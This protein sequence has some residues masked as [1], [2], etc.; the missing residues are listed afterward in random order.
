MRERKY[1]KFRVDMYEDTKLKI[2]DRKPERDLIN[3]IWTRVVI[4]AGKVN[5]EGDLFMS[6][7]IPYTIETLAI[8]FNRD[9]DHVELALNVL[10]ELEMIE[11]TEHKVYRVKNFAKH[12][13]IKVKEKVE[14]NKISN[15]AEI[16]KEEVRNE[17]IKNEEIKSEEDLKNESQIAI[18]EDIS[19]GSKVGE[20]DA[21][22]IKIDE[23][24]NLEITHKDISGNKEGMTKEKDSDNL[25]NNKSIPIEV[26]RG[27][28]KGR[29]K[30]NASIIEVIDGDIDSINDNVSGFF[31][32]ERPLGKDERIIK[33]WTFD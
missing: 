5:R 7:N 10:M 17:E 11:V 9:I 16:E 19:A 30:E 1:V 15:S 27:K 18:S 14:S 12:Q 2:I 6:K 3:Y 22:S 29:K 4:L 24:A 13:N 21:K 8:E 26:K 31:Q 32:E 25:K 33:S 20:N 28:G 23:A